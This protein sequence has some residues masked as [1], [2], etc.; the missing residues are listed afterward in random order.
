L[1]YFSTFQRQTSTFFTR[2]QKNFPAALKKEENRLRSSLFI[3]DET[4]N[5]PFLDGISGTF[6]PV[7]IPGKSGYL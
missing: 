7:N 1:K 5:D 3:G 4:K 2:A 6:L